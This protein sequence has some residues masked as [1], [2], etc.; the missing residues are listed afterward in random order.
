VA[1][2]ISDFAAGAGKY[3]LEQQ[4]EVLAG[5]ERELVQSVQAEH[6]SSDED[7]FAHSAGLDSP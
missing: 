7:V 2:S 4:L 5:F 3:D 6:D 1:G